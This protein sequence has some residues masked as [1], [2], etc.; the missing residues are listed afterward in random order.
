MLI[1]ESFLVWKNQQQKTLR[2]GVVMYDV[3]GHYKYLSEDELFAYWAN[4][5]QFK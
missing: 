1:V 3:K 4:D 5:K 2:G